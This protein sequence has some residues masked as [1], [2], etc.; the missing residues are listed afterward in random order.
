MPDKPEPINAT[1]MNITDTTFVGDVRYA[2]ILREGDEIVFKLQEGIRPSGI[3]P[4]P[5]GLAYAEEAEG[6][7]HIIKPDVP[8]DAATPD[9]SWPDSL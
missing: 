9:A 2:V 4:L 8:L 3:S 7:G 6:R 5:D 1:D